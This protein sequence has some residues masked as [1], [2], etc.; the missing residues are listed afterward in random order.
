MVTIPQS[1]VIVILPSGTRAS[2]GSVAE[3]VVVVVGDGLCVVDVDDVDAGFVGVSLGLW[4]A[5]AAAVAAAL[6]AGTVMLSATVAFPFA[7]IVVTAELRTA[8]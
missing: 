5:A 2:L 4:S 6:A 3:A 7:V 8:V 1:G